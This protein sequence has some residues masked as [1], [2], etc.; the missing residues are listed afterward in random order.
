M[1][2]LLCRASQ[3]HGDI[4]NLMVQ[5]FREG[6]WDETSNPHLFVTEMEVHKTPK[7]EGTACLFFNKQLYCLASI[8][9]SKLQPLVASP[10]K[11]LLPH[12]PLLEKDRHAFSL[13]FSGQYMAGRQVTHLVNKVIK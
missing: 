11:S 10:T 5:E 8:Y 6:Y 12:I 2:H 1:L 9:L 3:C 7:M 4:A 13:N